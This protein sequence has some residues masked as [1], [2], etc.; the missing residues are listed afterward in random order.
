[1]AKRVVLHVGA[2]K[3]GTTF[4]QST[5]YA[6]RLRLAELGVLVAGERW[7]AQV[8]A[9]LDVLGRTH[10]PTGRS[11]V[12]AWDRLVAEVGAWP[13]TAVVSVELLAPAGPKQIERIAGSFGDTD[14]EVVLSLRDLN[15]SLP[16]MWQ[17]TVQ[18]GRSWGW[19]EYVAGVERGRPRAGR[20]EDDVST[21]SRAFWRQQA[22]VRVA[23]H[24]GAAGPL[25]LVTVPRPGS[26]SSELLVRFAEVLGVDPTDLDAPVRGN[27]SLGAAST[28]VLRRMNG[29]LDRRGLAFPVGIRVRKRTLAKQILPALSAGERRIGLPVRPWTEEHAAGMVTGLRRLAPRLHGA[30]EDLAPVAVPGI[31]TSEVSSAEVAEATVA[32]YRALRDALASRAPGTGIARTDGMPDWSPAGTTSDEVADAGSVA[33]ADLVEWAVQASAAAA[34]A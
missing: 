32:A 10:H 28:E 4:L 15:R 23:R 3:S 8:D 20:T 34:E 22:G 5:L 16:A 30:W 18:N 6:N 19:E 29:V 25:H 11:V 1:M 14:L 17:E 27:A 31:P 7:G 9:V 33:L 12:G 13:G 26:P 21:L 24:W 2:M